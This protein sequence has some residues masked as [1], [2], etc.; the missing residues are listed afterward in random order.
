MFVTLPDVNSLL[1]T[2]LFLLEL[3]PYMVFGSKTN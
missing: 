1:L 3:Q 2:V